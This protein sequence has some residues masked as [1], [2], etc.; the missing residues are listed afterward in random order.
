[1]IFSK[2]IIKKSCTTDSKVIFVVYFKKIHEFI[3]FEELNVIYREDTITSS[4][5]AN[6]MRK[7]TYRYIFHIFYMMTYKIILKWFM[8]MF[9]IFDDQMLFSS[10]VDG[11]H[12]SFAFVHSSSRTWPIAFE[13]WYLIL[14]EW[15]IANFQ[16]SC[17]PKSSDKFD[18]FS[19]EI[20][21]FFISKN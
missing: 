13:S 11:D 21:K 10:F 12:T 6:L 7:I 5:N 15:K 8:I 9:R 14:C 18:V 3:I 17:T 1:M 19:C 4:Q 20:Y 16:F 2:N